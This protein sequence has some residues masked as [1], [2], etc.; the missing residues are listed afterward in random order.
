MF[1]N[2]YQFICTGIQPLVFVLTIIFFV[3]ACT[4]TKVTGQEPG[5]DNDTIG[6]RPPP[7]DTRG[8][9]RNYTGLSGC[10]YLIEVAGGDLYLP[11]SWPDRDNWTWEEGQVIRFSY[12]ELE[13]MA[14]ICMREKKIIEI[15][16]LDLYDE[17]T[18]VD[19]EDPMATE[20]MRD[21]MNE[22]APNEL[23]KYQYDGKPVYFFHITECCDRE[24]FLYNCE[25]VRLCVDGGITGGNCGFFKARWSDPVYLYPKTKNTQPILYEK[26]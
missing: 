25:G 5:G 26:P 7:C 17:E 18:C 24:S 6:E 9:V 14:S 3:S 2:A 4:G 16:C 22:M 8:V 15:L 1:K 19:T 20:W 13:D 23:I 12:T 10:T 21:L 11:S